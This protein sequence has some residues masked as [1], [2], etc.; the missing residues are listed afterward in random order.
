M[1]TRRFYTLFAGILLLAAL[2][3]GRLGYYSLVEGNGLLKQA[4][5]QRAMA[6]RLAPMRGNFYDRRMIP[7]TNRTTT[8]VL[9]VTTKTLSADIQT[10]LCQATGLTQEA[11]AVKLTQTPPII[12]P[13]LT[14][15]TWQENSTDVTQITVPERY[16]ENG[17]A[18]HTLGYIRSDGAG[19]AGLE[20]TF[21]AVLH[22]NRW[23]GVGYIGDAG[24]RVISDFGVRAVNCADD[25]RLGGVK[26]TLDYRLQQ[27]VE[28][29]AD[30][31][32]KGAIVMVDV[33]NGDIVATASRP[34]FS[35]NQPSKSMGGTHSE[36]VNRAFQPYNI[37]SIFKIVVAATALENNTVNLFD[38]F[39][40]TGKI[41]VD[42][43][44]F[45]CH[46][47]EGHGD[48]DFQKAFT[49]SCN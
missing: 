24:Q 12:M 32:T 22:D 48:I 14:G 40:C 16:S 13:M 9:V 1:Q 38:P 45:A 27:I 3:L 37:G 44:D 33:T 49:Q 25:T 47:A 8:Q 20:K 23:R 46:N 42:G 21:D 43:R 30:K 2:L 41:T 7:L 19:V 26:L 10:A 5:S 39:K 17:V 15:Q 29:S 36:L 6:I 35:Q 31:L 18:R 4:T 34:Q 28:Q 11:L